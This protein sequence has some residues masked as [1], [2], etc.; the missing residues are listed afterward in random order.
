[1]KKYY[2]DTIADEYMIA[3]ISDVIKKNQI[4]DREFEYAFIKDK[5]L[6]V[7]QRVDTRRRVVFI[8]PYVG[9]INDKFGLGASI[10]YQMK[11]DH[12]ISLHGDALNKGLY[13]STYWKLG[14]RK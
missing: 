11:N 5:V 9:A 7:T 8:G 14:L 6:T 13:F 2:K 1:M 3:I 12:M 4:W 10:L